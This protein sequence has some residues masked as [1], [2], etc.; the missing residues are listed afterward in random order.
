MTIKDKYI[1]VNGINTRYWRAG[2]KG[3]VVL[4]VHGFAASAE[5][6]MYNVEALAK[7]FRVIAVDMVGF[8]KSD[9][10]KIKYSADV[11]AEFI[12]NF[13]DV[14]KIKKVNFIGH[15]LGGAIGLKFAIDY[16]EYLEK[17]IL[18]DSAGFGQELPHGLKILTLPFIGRFLMH[19]NQRQLYAKALRAYAYQKKEITD[20]FVDK[21]FEIFNLPETKRTILAMLRQHATYFG[22]RLCSIKPILDNVDKIKAPT[23]IIWGAEDRMLPFKH[24]KTALKKIP[25]AVLRVFPHC[26]HIP[27]MEERGMFNRAVISFLTY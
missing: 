16:P 9:K 10:P 21:M 22:A 20:E 3:P 1:E 4:L 13:L 23:L 24:T 5:Y 26:G 12:K 15:S 18:V 11:L 17:L 19:F 2:N 6:W 27:Q 14:L 7:H 25:H 8:G